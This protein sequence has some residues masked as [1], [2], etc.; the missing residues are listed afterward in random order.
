MD[1]STVQ[2][3]TSDSRHPETGRWFVHLHTCVHACVCIEIWSIPMPRSWY[4]LQPRKQVCFA[5]FGLDASVLSSEL[6]PVRTCILPCKHTC[7]AVE[8]L[9]WLLTYLYI[10][11]QTSANP[12][13]C[14]SS[15]IPPEPLTLFRQI[16][17]IWLRPPVMGSSTCEVGRFYK[18]AKFY[19]CRTQ[20]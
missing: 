12:G 17:L 3:Y 7:V 8:V 9:L 13:G 6:N 11:L 10:W 15:Q 1:D 14:L 20:E 16:P 5:Q 2:Y 4:T 18:K 19:F